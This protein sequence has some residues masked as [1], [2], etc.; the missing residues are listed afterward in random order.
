[1]ALREIEAKDE[2]REALRRAEEEHALRGDVESWCAVAVAYLG[3]RHTV[4]AELVAREICER[5]PEIGIAWCTQSRPSIR[6]RAVPRRRRACP[7]VPRARRR[8]DRRTRA[9][10]ADPRT[11][12]SRG[13]GGERGARGGGDRG[14]GMP[15][16][17][18][19]E[20][21][22]RRPCRHRALRGDRHPTCAAG[23]RPP[24]GA[25]LRGGTPPEWLGA[26]AARRGHGVWAEDAPEWLARL[27]GAAPQELARFVVERI[28]AVLYWHA[29]T[30]PSP[31]G[32]TDP[33]GD[34]GF[35]GGMD[36]AAKELA[37]RT[38][39]EEAVN[40]ALRA[41]FELGYAEPDLDDGHERSGTTI[42]SA[43]A[44]EPHAAEIASCF[45]DELAIQLRASELAQ[46]VLFGSEEAGA[47]EYLVVRET[48]AGERLAW[49]QWGGTNKVFPNLD[50]IS[51]LSP[52]TRVRLETVLDLAQTEDDE[53]F[54]RGSG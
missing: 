49:I 35:A 40:A 25:P 32:G 12:R 20:R 42:V 47:K 15:R 6:A 39:C 27:A 37:H 16:G 13:P 28:E 34:E 21:G 22:A 1:M 9:S 29:I 2:E 46:P 52:A 44:W 48:L 54:R 7:K 30:E 11:D 19:L 33:A 51:E 5:H 45:G 31:Q 24:L 50:A 23:R 43:R 14:F 4:R 41:A 18:A 8:R 36:E 10:R 3:A 26:A 17:R 53:A 38:A